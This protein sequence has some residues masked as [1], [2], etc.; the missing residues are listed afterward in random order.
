MENKTTGRKTQA[1]LIDEAFEQKLSKKYDIARAR[2]DIGREI[3]K[4]I[5]IITMTIDHVG[6]IIYPT[7]IVL[8]YIGRLSFPLFCYLIALGVESTRNI[9]KYFMRLFIFSI[10]SQV[11]FYLA[12]GF[13]PFETLNILF[14]LSSGVLFIHFLKKKDPLLILPLFAAAILNFDYGIY[15]TLSIGCMYLLRRDTGL[16]ITLFAL[17]TVLF[18]T[19]SITQLLSLFSIPIILLYKSYL[20]KM[21]RE[22]S[23]NR[24]Y[25]IWKK[26]LYYAYYPLHLTLLYLIKVFFIMA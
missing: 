8:R 20:F 25:P 16:G 10:I 4:W 19:I 22:I 9:E 26:G 3:L 15:G 12:L 24:K 17:F 2:F 6:A 11:P 18:S 1:K 14:T 23:G 7:Q 21:D 13:K 5:A